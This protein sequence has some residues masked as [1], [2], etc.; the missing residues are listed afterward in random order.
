MILVLGGSGFLGSAIRDL[1]PRGF[2]FV[3]RRCPDLLGGDAPDCSGFDA[4]LYC[5]D[6][7]PGLARTAEDAG[8]VRDT[9]VAMFATAL[10]MARTT[11]GRRIVSIGTTACYPTLDEPMPETMFM[12]EPL[13]PKMRGYA[14]SRADWILNARAANVR[15]NHLVL[16][17]LYGPRDQYEAGRSHLLASWLRDLRASGGRMKM[18]GDGSNRREFMFVR[19]AAAIVVRLA[20]EPL[21]EEILNVGGGFTPTYRELAESACRALGVEP[22]LEW[23]T[24]RAGRALEVMDSRKLGRVVPRTP[25]CDTLTETVEWMEAVA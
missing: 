15:H 17:N 18:R 11:K 25:F 22:S 6:W 20:A 12:E 23:E 3:P 19:D 5:A 21:A 24:E 7:Y 16:P 10:R 1:E 4:I 14:Q 13:N 2:N 8:L 9:N